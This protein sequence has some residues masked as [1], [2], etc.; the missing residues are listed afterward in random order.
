MEQ[1]MANGQDSAMA[2]QLAKNER[3]VSRYAV[4]AKQQLSVHEEHQ[5][6]ERIVLE[7]GLTLVQ[8]TFLFELIAEVSGMFEKSRIILLGPTAVCAAP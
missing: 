4:N 1:Q 3:L 5:L 7:K 2:K 6:R 8:Y